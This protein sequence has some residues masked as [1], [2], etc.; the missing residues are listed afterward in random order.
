MVTVGQ[1]LETGGSRS[2]IRELLVYDQF[3]S[4]MMSVRLARHVFAIVGYFS[5][6]A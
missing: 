1:K 6:R 4:V 2:S 3:S 5:S